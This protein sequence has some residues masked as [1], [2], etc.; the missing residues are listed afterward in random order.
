MIQKYG[1][2]SKM[3]LNMKNRDFIGGLFW[4]GVGFFFISGALKYGLFDEGI[5]APGLF[6][7]ILG[8]VLSFLGIGVLIPAFK[9]ERGE[10]LP[11]ESFFP[12]KNSLKKV[13][14]A[15]LALSVYGMAL[16]FL[17][18]LVMTFLFMVF[19]LRCI[20]PQRWTV[21]SV[22]SILTALSSYVLFQILLK[23]Q[24]PKG[25]LGI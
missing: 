15:V 23:V 25:I 2:F 24:L 13:F 20:E 16:E 17:G 21:V 7:L 22:A 9:E 18:F 11:K 3:Q 1:I 8:I 12:E 14:L 5:P 10:R 19:L 4:I 6:P